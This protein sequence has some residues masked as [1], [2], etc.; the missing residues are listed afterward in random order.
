MN[1]DLK[2]PLEDDNGFE[3]EVSFAEL[4]NDWI[5]NKNVSKEKSDSLKREKKEK[6]GKSIFA[7]IDEMVSRIE[8][9]RK[10][11]F[12]EVNTF[13]IKSDNQEKEISS[14]KTELQRMKNVYT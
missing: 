11:L 8:E 14:L 10:D 7:E 9:E 3:T 5:L 6:T 13:L 4:R 1:P 12:E 2:I